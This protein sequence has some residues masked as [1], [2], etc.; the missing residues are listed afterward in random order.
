MVTISV[1]SN[2][3]DI[4]QSQILVI[5]LKATT[6]YKVIQWSSMSADIT[7]DSDENGQSAYIITQKKFMLM[8]IG[9]VNKMEHRHNSS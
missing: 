2:N 8:V 5:P 3:T 6:Y 4:K 1:R 7:I 9:V